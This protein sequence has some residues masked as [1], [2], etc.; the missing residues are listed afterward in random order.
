MFI[1]GDLLDA[2]SQACGAEAIQTPPGLAAF[3]DASTL[4]EGSGNAAER[5]H[6]FCDKCRVAPERP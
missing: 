1:F 3:R 4:A 6:Q 5:R 2:T